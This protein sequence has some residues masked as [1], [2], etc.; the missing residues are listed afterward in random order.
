MTEETNVVPSLGLEDLAEFATK[1]IYK[2]AGGKK[3][4][5]HTV[6]EARELVKVKDQNKVKK[7]GIQALGLN[8][9]RCLL[10]LDKIKAKAT[11][12]VVSDDKAE[13]IV[14]ALLA[15]VKSGV[16]D[17][18]IA[19]GIAQ[20]KATAEKMAEAANAKN[21]IDD[22]VPVEGGEVDGLDIDAI[23]DDGADVEQF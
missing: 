18:E 8:L 11:R 2:S 5:D 1:A 3:L 19:V 15:H 17:E 16:F 20:A 14:E 10:P 21:D 23:E 12:L 4:Y 6:E 7:E 9:G 22:S 13:G